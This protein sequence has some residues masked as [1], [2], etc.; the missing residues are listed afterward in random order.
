MDPPQARQEQQGRN[1]REMFIVA[2]R[3]HRL[4]SNKCSRCGHL[5]L[6]TIYYCEK[7]FNRKFESFEVEG[8]GKVVTYTIQAVSPEGFEDIGS[9]AWVVFAVDG[10]N[11][12]VSGCLPGIMSTSDLPIGSRVKVS[13]FHPKHGLILQKV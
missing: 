11:F 5:M 8:T 2:A 10:T 1:P 7:C 9:Y 12:S 6:P 3:K 4:L 13:D